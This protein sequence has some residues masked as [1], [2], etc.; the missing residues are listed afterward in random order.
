M[1][2]NTRQKLQLL[3]SYKNE[4]SARFPPRQASP[5]YPLSSAQWR[6]VLEIQS[7]FP[8]SEASFN[9]AP[10]LSPDPDPASSPSAYDEELE[11]LLGVLRAYDEELTR[12]RHSREQAYASALR[13]CVS[14][15]RSVYELGRRL[16][17]RP[18]SIER[19]VEQEKDLSKHLHGASTC[20]HIKEQSDK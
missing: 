19:V 6:R 16:G 8:A 2:R 10:C 15:I 12:R 18:V 7:L 1:T 13:Q 5:S 9:P 4:L 17:L 14:Q 20:K 11:H 3:I